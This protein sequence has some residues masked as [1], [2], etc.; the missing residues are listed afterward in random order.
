MRKPKTKTTKKQGHPPIVIDY[1]L[2][3]TLGK[4]QPTDVELADALGIS[5]DTIGRRRKT[6]P[7]FVRRLE[8]GK[9]TGLLS[10]RRTQWKSAINGNITMQIWLGKQYLG[11]KDRQELS[12]DA[13][14]PIE[15][16]VSLAEIA[17]EAMKRRNNGS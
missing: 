10:L 2:L 3:E 7:E 9:N 11:Q 16:N 12:G 1:D 6:D 5:H 8:K 17:F 14:H 13:E 15:V 4:L